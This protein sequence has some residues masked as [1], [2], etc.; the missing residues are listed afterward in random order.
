[1]YKAYPNIGYFNQRLWFIQN[2]FA[3]GRSILPNIKRKYFNIGKNTGLFFGDI[4]N[5]KSLV[6]VEGPF[7]AMAAYLMLKIPSV[8]IGGKSRYLDFTEKFKKY[9]IIVVI[10]N[11]IELNYSF[12][13]D[14]KEGTEFYKPESQYKDM[15][16]TYMANQEPQF[17]FK[18]TDPIIE[19]FKTKEVLWFFY[20]YHLL[21]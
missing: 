7:D 15:F 9:N 21:F 1:M 5:T 4:S 20:L 18:L 6:L 17:L 16:S 12:V 11:D 3:T 13:K 19:G 10:D 14:F 8:S 2:D